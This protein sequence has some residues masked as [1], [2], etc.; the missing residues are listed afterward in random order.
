MIYEGPKVQKRH[1][2]QRWNEVAITL[3]RGDKLQVHCSN[4]LGPLKMHFTDVLS[5]LLA[6]DIN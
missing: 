5:I 4:F 3:R 2:S 6:T 1:G